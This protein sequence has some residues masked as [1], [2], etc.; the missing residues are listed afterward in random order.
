MANKE[1]ISLLSKYQMR[2]LYYKCKEGAT[3]EEIAEK[4]GR[5]V[6][7]VQ[8][9]MSKIYKILEI[10]E[11]GKSKEE[12]DSEL[13]NEICPIIRQMF[14]TIDDVRIWAPSIKKIPNEQSGK[15]EE[16]IKEIEEGEPISP[17]QPPPSVEKI[18]KQTVIQPTIP[19]II[20]PPPPGRTRINWRRIIIWALIALLIFVVWRIYLYYSSN[21]QEPT[22]P[23]TQP[24]PAQIEPPIEPTAAPTSTPI[25]TATALPTPTLPPITTPVLIEIVTEVSSRDGMVLVKVAAG[26]FKMGS[27]RADDPQTFEEEM[28]QHNVYLDAYWI[29][30]TEVTNAQYAMCVADGGACTNPLYNTSS[31][32]S[33]YYDN[34]QYANYPVVLVSW[35]QAAAYCA[36]AGR[37]LPTEAEWEKAARGPD[38]RIYPWGNPFDGTIANYCDI[39]C[40]NPWKG[41]YD[42]GFTDTSPVGAYPSGAS[43]YGALDMAGNIYE[44][45]ADWYGPYSPI[46]QRNPTGPTSGLEHIIRGGSWGDD[47]AHIRAAVRSHI[48]APDYWTDY[49]G[50]RCAR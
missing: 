40:N 18:I 30:Q 37:R 49:I 47:S 50:F 25:D 48:N 41:P 17:Y 4:L 46:D 23:P 38:G 15:F 33:S 14:H 12:M 28:P 39:N 13:K 16:E 3:H 26:E 31:T 35:S 10:S 6:N 44:W 11:P 45:V 20:E 7:T 29:D 43:V 9:H 34:S 19:Q 21:L 27:S 24:N 42:D 32:R 1:N 5:D 2:V 22:P 8:Y 36:W